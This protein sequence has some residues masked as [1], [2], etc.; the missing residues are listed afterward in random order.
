MNVNS[1]PI[2]RGLK[3][4]IFE[5]ENPFHICRIQLQKK[6]SGVKKC[7]E[8]CAIKGGGRRLMANAILNLHFDYWHTSLILLVVVLMMMEMV[9]MLFLAGSDSKIGVRMVSCHPRLL[10]GDASVP[11]ACHLPQVFIDCLMVVA[12]VMKLMLLAVM[13]L[14]L[15]VLVMLVLVVVEIV[16]PSCCRLCQPWPALWCLLLPARQEI[17][18]PY[19]LAI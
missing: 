6:K 19:C 4:D 13:M 9:L 18:L 10:P 1:E 11:I 17:R 16:S 3:S 15:P 2:I 12:I 8:I 14:G 7:L 5:V